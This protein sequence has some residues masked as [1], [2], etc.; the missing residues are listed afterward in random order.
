MLRILIIMLMVISCR[1]KEQIF[2]QK[3]KELMVLNLEDSR[4]SDIEKWIP[5]FDMKTKRFTDLDYDAINSNNFEPIQSLGRA[6]IMLRAFYTK[7][8]PHYKKEILRTIAIQSAKEW[9]GYDP[10]SYNWWFNMIG[11]QLNYMPIMLYEFDQFSP[12]EKEKMKEIYLR[13][14]FMFEGKKFKGQNLLWMSDLYMLRSY[15]FN[16]PQDMKLAL[17]EIKGL[18]KYSPK[19]DGFQ[20]DNS[21]F[22]HGQLIYQGGYGAQFTEVMGK[23]FYLLDGTPFA[24]NP[25]EYEFFD[26]YVLDGQRIVTDGYWIDFA[27]AGRY[28]SRQYFAPY[29]VKQGVKYMTKTTSSRK[30]EYEDYYQSLVHDKRLGLKLN[31]HFFV[32]DMMV[33]QHPKYYSS[34]RMH[35]IRTLNTDYPSNNEGLLFHNMA[36]GVFYYAALPKEY[37][38]IFPFWDYNKLPGTTADQRPLEP[39]V[40]NPGVESGANMVSLGASKFVG[41]AS[42][43]EFGVCAMDFKKAHVKYQLTAKKSWFYFDEVVIALGA[44]INCPDCPSDVTT[45][46]DQTRLIKEEKLNAINLLSYNDK[47]LVNLGEQPFSVQTSTIKGDWYRINYQMPKE[48]FS[49]KMRLIE[50]KHGKKPKNASYAYA[51]YPYDPHINPLESYKWHNSKDKQMVWQVSGEAFQ[52]VLYQATSIKMDKIELS[53]DVPII[54]ILKKQNQYWQLALADP[55]KRVNTANLKIKIGLQIIKLKIDFPKDDKLGKTVIMKFDENAKVQVAQ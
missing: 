32:G 15:F 24:F 51:Y 23:Y 33:Q 27:V 17:D 47:M 52:G 7:G 16:R 42:D 54:F 12:N 21:F 6:S 39:T 46:I 11:V 35:S 50:I 37:D 30:K 8:H 14:N 9:L 5:L 28:F 31:H 44:G 38:K 19:S 25:V 22:Q 18:L 41:G 40:Y 26:R 2:I 20:V 43:G 13:S 53:S 48:Q 55:L 34:V 45:T 36:D 1:D 4:S 3:Y 49:E 10:Q 29:S